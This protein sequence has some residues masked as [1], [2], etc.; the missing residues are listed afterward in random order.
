M[1]E[2]NLTVTLLQGRTSGALICAGPPWTGWISATPSSQA[3]ISMASLRRPI[4][5][6]VVPDSIVQHSSEPHWSKPDLES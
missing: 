4:P 1:R 6:H 3:A 5:T 2:A